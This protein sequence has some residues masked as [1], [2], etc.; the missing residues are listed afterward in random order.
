M[1]AQALRRLSALG[2]LAALAACSLN[3]PTSTFPELGPDANT[4]GFGRRFPVDSSNE[5]FQFGVGDEVA[6]KVENGA[7]Y[8]GSYRV[9]QDGRVSIPIIGEVLIGGL[10]TSQVE[11]KL[12]RLLAVYETDPVVTV[13]VGE[14]RSKKIFVTTLNPSNGGLDFRSV[15]YPGDMTMADL[16]AQIG[17]PSTVLDDDCHVF[18]IRADP[19]FP[20]KYVI[21][22]REVITGGYTGAN[23]QLRPDDIV[24]VPPTFL[25]HLNRAISAVTL[26]M[27]SVVRALGSAANVR[28]Q[29]RIIEGE[30]RF[31]RFQNR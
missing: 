8:D 25:G 9:R 23:F 13:G 1:L 19:R 14:V 20:R 21:N 4:Q 27:Q 17:S 24:Y 31:R 5:E 29:V 15:P 10:S 28:G 22:M 3:G 12:I 6:L 16:W 2:L 30:G 11:R 7:E 26:P 18:L